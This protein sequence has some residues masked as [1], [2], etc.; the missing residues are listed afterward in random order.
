M[1]LVSGV[2]RIPLFFSEVRQEL[3]NVSWSTREE[4]FGATWVVI[5]ITLLLAVYI[6]CLDLAL[7]KFLTTVL[8]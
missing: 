7:S 6:G 4:L 3:K 5:T 1:G 2:K 8:K